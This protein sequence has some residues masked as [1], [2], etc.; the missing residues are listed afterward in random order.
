MALSFSYAILEFID[1]CTVEDHPG[2]PDQ[3]G[4]MQAIV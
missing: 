2:L 3:F 4:E 1:F